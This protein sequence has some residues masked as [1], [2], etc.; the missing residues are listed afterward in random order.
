MNGLLRK[1]PSFIKKNKLAKAKAAEDSDEGFTG[2]HTASE[3][4]SSQFVTR[5]SAQS[6]ENQRKDAIKIMEA[7]RMSSSINQGRATLPPQ[8]DEELERMN[9]ARLPS[10]PLPNERREQ[11]AQL[12]RPFHSHAPPQQAEDVSGGINTH[13]LQDYNSSYVSSVLTDDEQDVISQIGNSRGLTNTTMGAYE[14]QQS[15]PMSASEGNDE[16]KREELWESVVVLNKSHR[17][18]KENKSRTMEKSAKSIKQSVAKVATPAPAVAAPAARREEKIRVRDSRTYTY[19]PR[20]QNH[21]TS[22]VERAS[23][24]KHQHKR[25]ISTQ[26]LGYNYH[27][28][29]PTFNHAR[30]GA[31]QER[32]SEM[33]RPIEHED[34][35]EEEENV[36][37]L[38]SMFF[39][40]KNASPMLNSSAFLHKSSKVPSKEEIEAQKPQKVAIPAKVLKAINISKGS[41]IGEN[42]PR[43]TFAEKKEDTSAPTK[44]DKKSKS[45]IGKFSLKKRAAKKEES[46]DDES[47]NVHPSAGKRPAPKTEF[48]V[49]ADLFASATSIASFTEH[50]P[51]PRAAGPKLDCSTANMFM[52]MN[53]GNVKK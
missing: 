6:Q 27:Q 49:K 18:A 44:A 40:Q 14:L 10:A 48:K 51:A 11:Q 36:L 1:F 5:P 13:K 38:D 20:A 53:T 33:R 32:R 15:Q 9:I 29:E 7:Q 47:G 23:L 31:K 52:R 42:P 22:T 25:K 39:G 41:F 50:T 45:K 19:A 3:T 46:S 21:R 17:H 28:R 8:H 24:M 30:R 16:A 2:S 26:G 34:D 12:N 4:P 43:V 35:A 37:V